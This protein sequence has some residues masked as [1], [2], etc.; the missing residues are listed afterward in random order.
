MVDQLGK[1]SLSKASRPKDVEARLQKVE[2][3]LERLIT[4]GMTGEEYET[5]E[6][7][8]GLPN[9]QIRQAEIPEFGVASKVC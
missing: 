6:T 8:N 4:G 3:S 9:P 1:S 7:E 2:R 5:D